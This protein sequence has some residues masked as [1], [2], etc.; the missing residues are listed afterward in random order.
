MKTVEVGGE[1]AHQLGRYWV[2]DRSTDP[3]GQA[4]NCHLTLIEQLVQ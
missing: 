4:V 1:V 2:P 3:G